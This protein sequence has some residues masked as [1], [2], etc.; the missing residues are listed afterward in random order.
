MWSCTG[1]GNNHLPMMY[2]ALALGGHIRVGLEDNLYYKKGV[3]A[4]NQQFVARAV[5]V[6]RNIGRE[7]ATPSEA[8]T[9]LGIKPFIKK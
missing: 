6:A 7:P 1:V 2:A 9:M 4:S 5:R 3:K 8:R